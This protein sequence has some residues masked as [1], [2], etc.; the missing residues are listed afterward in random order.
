MVAVLKK[1]T[2]GDFAG[3][4]GAWWDGR[5]YSPGEEDAAPKSQE[6]PKAK[7]S[8]AEAKP[9]KKESLSPVASRMAAIETLWGEGRFA[10]AS[11]ELYS[12]ICDVLPE[13][14]NG[15]GD[16]FG[17][18]NS[19]PAWLGQLLAGLGATP[20]VSEW[21]PPCAD[22]FKETYPD[23][24]LFAGD[25]DRPAFDPGSLS[26]AF[27]QDAFAFADHKPGLAVRMMR[28][29]APGGQWVVLDTVR[30][31]T[32]GNL[33]PAFASAWAEPQLPR[34]DEIIEIC[35]SAGFELVR[36]GDDV[37]G[38][39]LQACRKSLKEFGGELENRLS[40][41]LDKANR[42]V[43]MQELGWEAE[44]WKWRE[45]AFAAELIHLK[46]WKFRKPAE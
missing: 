31:E 3:R 46:L 11:T 8:V 43:F 4:L 2:S 16:V 37:T 5:D 14:E 35:E 39:M 29:L 40:E 15:M 20:V 6:K 27:S 19:D 33:A 38:D 42:V 45:R 1:L 32:N 44:T 26:A 22:R 41:G 10:P 18:L 13:L 25:L 28:S 9:A 17:V 21:R 23:F 34:E 24:D 12:R 30:G 7:T 36:E